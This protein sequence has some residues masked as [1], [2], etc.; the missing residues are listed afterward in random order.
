MT[1][2][3]NISSL[4]TILLLI[5]C[6]VTSAYSQTE[7][8]LQREK[9]QQA[10]K[11]YMNNILLQRQ[12]TQPEQNAETKGDFEKKYINKLSKITGAKD[13]KHYFMTGN[14]I[15]VE[16]YNY[17]GIGPGYGLI[18]N[19]NNGVWRG[20]SYIFQ[21]CPLVAASVPSGLDPNQQLHIISDGLWDYPG[22]REFNPDDPNELWSF[23]PLPGYADPNQEYMASNPAEDRDGDGK[24]DSWPHSWYNPILGKYV[25][26][27]FLAQ[28]AT[29]ADLEV[30]W[31]MDD[32]D[33]K[34][35][36]Y[37]PFPSDSTRKG[38]G[39]QKIGR[40]HV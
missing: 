11:E 38:L 27:G 9:E 8:E 21:F 22:L 5:L 33:N 37:Y 39:I 24:P 13:R 16:V 19:V 40:A 30:F 23:Q 32:R 7:R 15:A 26:P 28:D 4:F 20:L 36:P 10:V 3:K 29:N 1:I 6:V 12:N 14:N 31:A 34:E 35:F 25:W 2:T 17:G 18:R